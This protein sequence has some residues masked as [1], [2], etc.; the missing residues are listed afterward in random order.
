MIQRNASNE[1]RSS[2]PLISRRTFYYG[3]TNK[4]YTYCMY[5]LWKQLIV[6]NTLWLQSA[7][8]LLGRTMLPVLQPKL[9]EP[10]VSSDVTSTTATKMSEKL[11][12]IPQYCQPWNMLHQSVTYTQV[13]KYTDLQ[14]QRRGM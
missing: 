1:S 4:M 3:S 9:Q 6:Q 8:T 5:T 13:L 12:S 11:H 14:T 10:L 7:R 2:D